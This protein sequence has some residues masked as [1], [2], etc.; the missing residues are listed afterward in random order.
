MDKV[1]PFV[2]N[3]GDNDFSSTGKVGKSLFVETAAIMRP[4]MP[5]QTQI[6][7]CR[8][9]HFGGLP[10]NEIAACNDI[11]VMKTSPAVRVT[12]SLNKNDIGMWRNAF[13][14]RIEPT[15][16]G[17]DAGYVCAMASPTVAI[18][19]RH[20][21]WMK[22]NI[23]FCPHFLPTILRQFQQV[24]DAGTVFILKI[25]VCEINT[26]IENTE[27][28]AFALIGLGQTGSLM[29]QICADGITAGIHQSLSRSTRL[30]KADPRVLCQRTQGLNWSTRNHNVAHLGPALDSQGLQ[31]CCCTGLIE[32]DEE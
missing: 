2:A 23:I 19:L 20:I 3:G 27:D 21:L 17:G 4:G 30:D 5:A 6:N 24:L 15:S 12:G 25:R 18:A 8:L 29:H 16:S 31:I 26:G 1:E 28:N 32:L 9:V 11:G 10:K 14:R 13:H 7:D 22:I